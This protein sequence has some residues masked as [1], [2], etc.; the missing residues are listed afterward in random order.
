MRCPV[1]A[2]LLQ[3]LELDQSCSSS[4]SRG[5]IWHVWVLRNAIT[6]SHSHAFAEA[7]SGSMYSSGSGLAREGCTLPC[8]SAQSHICA[9][10]DVAA[11]MKLLWAVLTD[12]GAHQEVMPNLAKCELLPSRSPDTQLVYQHVFSQ[13]VFWRV[14]A[15]AVL[16]VRLEESADSPGRKALNFEMVS[17]DF[18]ELTGRW[19][20]YPDAAD[21]SKASTLQYEIVFTPDPRAQIPSALAVFLLKQTLPANISALATRAEQVAKVRSCQH[22]IA[23]AISTSVRACC[24]AIPS[25][26]K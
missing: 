14:E 8:S 4:T 26:Y 19:V 2:F 3:N 1:A 6:A 11:P 22:A 7:R 9:K 16:E 21:P 20:V 10:V 5:H 13:T 12:F 17:G 18:A 24:H 25:D 15:S 23:I